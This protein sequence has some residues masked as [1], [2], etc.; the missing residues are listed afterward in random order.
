MIENFGQTPPQ[1]CHRPHPERFSRNETIYPPLFSDLNLHCPK[2][3]TPT[4]G[5]QGIRFDL[6]LFPPVVLSKLPITY[7]S[8][9]SPSQNMLITVDAARVIGRHKWKPEVSTNFPPF[10][11]EIDPSIANITLTQYVGAPHASEVRSSNYQQL[12][13]VSGDGLFLLS[14]S[15]WDFSIRVTSLASTDM[16]EVQRLL[17]KDVVTSIA[18]CA[19][20][21]HLVTG[22]LDSTVT[23]WKFSTSAPK[24]RFGGPYSSF[25]ISKAFP[26]SFITLSGS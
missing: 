10:S 17:Q 24:Y 20:S 16:K 2:V 6:I 9:L 1:L 12:Y 15:H 7:M 5:G 19:E 26:M 22:S 11:L 18:T 14:C 13:A 23:V 8:I 25:L 3:C 21:N 4:I